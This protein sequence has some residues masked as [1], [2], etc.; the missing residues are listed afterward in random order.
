MKLPIINLLV[1]PAANLSEEFFETLLQRPGVRVERIISTGQATPA[2]EWYDQAWDEWVLILSGAA[3]LRSRG[4]TN[5][6]ACCR[7]T[8]CC[9]RR[10]VAT[11]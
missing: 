3:S 7:A 6:A 5:R 11:G 10:T 9:C 2:G 4:R 1:P 8:A